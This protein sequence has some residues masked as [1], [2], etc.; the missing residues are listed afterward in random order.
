MGSNA[1]ALP[2]GLIVVADKLVDLCKSDTKFITAV[3]AH[4]M[5]HLHY[6]HGMVLLTQVSARGTVASVVWGDFSGML[7]SISVLLRTAAY[8]RDA[9]RQADAFAAKVLIDLGR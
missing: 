2:G 1:F 7:A 6:R 9:E 4:V 3:L 8:S 5:G